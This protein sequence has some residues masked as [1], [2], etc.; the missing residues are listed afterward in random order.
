[1][2]SFRLYFPPPIVAPVREVKDYS[3]EERAKLRDDFSSIAKAYRRL[4]RIVVY[5]GCG[6]AGF[7]LLGWVLP[8]SLLSW[9]IGFAIIPWLVAMFAMTSRPRLSCPGCSNDMEWGFSRYCPE[10]GGEHVQVR[11]SSRAGFCSDCAKFMRRG[12]GRNYKIRACT[13]CGLM[14]DQKGL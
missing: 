5:A 2:K 4:K 3:A 13:H 12:R 14:L 9:C 6:F 11:T 10:C 1:L 8:K 7:V